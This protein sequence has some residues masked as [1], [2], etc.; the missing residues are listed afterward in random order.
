MNSFDNVKLG[1][2]VEKLIIDENFRELEE[3]LYNNFKYKDSIIYLANMY[4][5]KYDKRQIFKGSIPIN[6]HAIVMGSFLSNNKDILH[7]V[8]ED[9]IK[10]MIEELE[11]SSEL[12]EYLTDYVEQKNKSSMY[13]LM[14]FLSRFS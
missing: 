3:F 14:S 7:K 2:T 5:G 6:H 8:P 1:E 9:F 10:N 4:A 12:K 13:K 11:D